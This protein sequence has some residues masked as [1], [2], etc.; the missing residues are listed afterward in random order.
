[1]ILIFISP[2]SN[3]HFTFCVF[4]N[5]GLDFCP[6]C[7]LGRSISLLFR[8]DITASFDS[9]PLGL[10]AIAILSFRVYSLIKKQIQK[11]QSI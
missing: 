8:G 6:G 10:I 1:M 3:S 9:H 11:I 7:G 2:D 4:N 5:V